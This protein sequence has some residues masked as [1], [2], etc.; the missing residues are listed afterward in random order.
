VEELLRQ[1]WDNGS[2]DGLLSEMGV[3]VMTTMVVTV[4]N[5]NHDLRL[6]RVGNRE[7]EDEYQG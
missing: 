5:D 3:I 1:G 4:V 2:F 6:R 7:A